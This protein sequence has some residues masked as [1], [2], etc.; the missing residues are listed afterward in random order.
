MKVNVRLKN[1]TEERRDPNSLQPH[2]LV[3]QHRKYLHNQDDKCQPMQFLAECLQSKTK[4]TLNPSV[5]MK[6]AA[7]IILNCPTTSFVIVIM[8]CKQAEIIIKPM[9]QKTTKETLLNPDTTPFLDEMYENITKAAGTNTSNT[10]IRIQVLT[11]RFFSSGFSSFSSPTVKVSRKITTK[12]RRSS[13]KNYTYEWSKEY[14][15]DSSH[16]SVLLHKIGFNGVQ[17]GGLL[18]LHFFGRLGLHIGCVDFGIGEQCI[19]LVSHTKQLKRGIRM[20]EIRY[21]EQILSQCSI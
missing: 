15:G 1:W 19:L 4:K 16:V 3:P 8:R 10:A 21:R 14:T 9:Q 7:I 2:F 18:L 6:V 11:G 17:S 20:G 5:S 12:T 13:P